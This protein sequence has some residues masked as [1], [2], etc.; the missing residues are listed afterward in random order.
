MTGTSLDGIDVALGIVTG[1][2]LEVRMRFLQHQSGALQTLVNGLR[3]AAEQRPLTAE[4]LATLSWQLGEL[5]AA[6]IESALAGDAQPDL[7]AVHGQTV[8]HR[9]PVSWQL[10]NPAPIA[11]RFGCP[12]VGDLRQA[13]LAAGGSGAPITPMAD[14]VLFRNEAR[15][16]AIVNLGGF[17][18]MTLLPAAGGDDQLLR[19]EGFDLCA[20]N[21]VLDAVAR[22][23]LHQPFDRDG[24]AA[25]AGAERPELVTDLQRLLRGQRAAGRSLGSGDELIDWVR[26]R[27]DRH[28]P[29]DLARSAVCAIAA[30]IAEA[31]Q[32]AE[33]D[34]LVLA[35]GGALN[36]T[37][38]E[39]IEE[40]SE[41][42]VI[43]SG[44][45]GVPVQAREAL[46]MAI[47]G[48]LCADGIP[49]TLPQVT[50]CRP[51]APLSGV[52]WGP[53]G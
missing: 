52:W 45:L 12:V 22:E 49:I 31:T 4:R 23:A 6:R 27:L 32:A 28:L 19:I 51:P 24:A 35:G 10:V 11:E 1:H 14:W 25:R 15:R 5:Y 42:A 29:E 2:G 50:G 7:I 38:R 47:L 46:C 48:A 17:C 36:L 44:Q 41:C 40:R 20:C 34:E 13:D 39:Q 8:F 43:D 18:N 3:D 37:L 21:H 53:R 16:R 33:V 26:R 9:P 30:T